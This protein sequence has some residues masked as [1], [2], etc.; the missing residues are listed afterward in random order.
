MLMHGWMRQSESAF[1][2]DMVEKC[3]ELGCCRC[4]RKIG[5]GIAPDIVGHKQ[6]ECRRAA[7]GENVALM[8][9]DDESRV[10]G[11]ARVEEPDEAGAGA[12][13]AGADDGAAEVAPD[14]GE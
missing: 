7:A 6:H 10:V 4:W 3:L 2:T 9:A 11:I 14:A 8:R 13:E 1:S 5:G 12:D